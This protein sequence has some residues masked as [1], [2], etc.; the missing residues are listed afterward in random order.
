MASKKKFTIEIT[1]AVLQELFPDILPAD[2][3]DLLDSLEGHREEIMEAVTEAIDGI[4]NQEDEDDYEDDEEEYD[5][6]EDDEDDDYD[7]E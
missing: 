6:D 4:L 7:D 5:E 2:A 3:E 1:Q